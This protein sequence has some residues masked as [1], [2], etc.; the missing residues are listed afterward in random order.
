[1]LLDEPVAALSVKETK[2]VL[3]T[4]RSFKDKKLASVIIV[5]HNIYQIYSIVDKFIVMARGKKIGDIIRKDVE[6]EDIIE[7]ITSS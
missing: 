5:A 2:K 7:M 4:I 1:L 6:P 3:D